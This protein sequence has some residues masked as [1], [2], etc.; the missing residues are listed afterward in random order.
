MHLQSK[1]DDHPRLCYGLPAH[2]AGCELAGALC[3]AARD[4]GTFCLCAAMGGAGCWE[5]QPLMNAVRPIDEGFGCP[6][7]G[8]QLH[9]ARRGDGE[10][11]G[12]IKAA[13]LVTSPC[14]VCPD[15]QRQVATQHC[16]ECDLFLCAVC[17]ATVHRHPVL[18]A[19]IP[20]SLTGGADTQKVES[21]CGDES[22]PLHSGKGAYILAPA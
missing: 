10:A 21:H 5:R 8:A 12:A 6:Q 9:A 15:E 2:V 11:L 19:H 22:F 16:V 4:I 17:S 3:D 13:A 14:A 1:W 18:K 20:Q 7:F